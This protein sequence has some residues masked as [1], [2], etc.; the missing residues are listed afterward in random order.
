MSEVAKHVASK[1]T[2]RE[3]KKKTGGNYTGLILDVRHLTVEQQKFFHIVDEKGAV[4]YGIE[5]TDK[6]KQAKEGL[7]VYYERIVLTADE[8]A[9]VGDNPLVIRAQRFSA[10]GE[11]IVIPTSEAEKIR[12]NKIDFRKDCKVIVV[13]S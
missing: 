13:R 2:P 3:P 1:T 7:C 8:K 5:Y 9:R 10:N 4:V 12:T 6:N 11:D